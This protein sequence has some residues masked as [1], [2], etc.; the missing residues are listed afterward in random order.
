MRHGV[1]NSWAVKTHFVPFIFEDFCPATERT[2]GSSL[3]L[4]PDRNLIGD[5]RC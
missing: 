3:M 2:A 1:A 5:T 4:V